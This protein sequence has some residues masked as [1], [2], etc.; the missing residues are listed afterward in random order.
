MIGPVFSLEL[1]LGSRRGRLD[2]LRRL[3]AGWLV[4]QWLVLFL[5]YLPGIR[6]GDPT[7]LAGVSRF[8]NTYLEIFVAQHF[9]LL[10]L[11]APVFVAGA[12]TDEKAKGT[13]THLLTADLTSWEI[14]AGKLLGRMAQVG[15]LALTGFPMLGFMGGY[16][17]LGWL[18][19]VSL[20]AVTVAPFFAL[21]AA[22]MLA[23]VRSVQTRDAVLRVYF[24][25]GLVLLGLWGTVEALDHFVIWKLTPNSPLHQRLLFGERMLHTLNPVHVL[26]PLW[27]VGDPRELGWRLLAGGLLWG[28]AGALCLGLAVWRLR[29]AYVRQLEA[30]AAPPRG[31][32]RRARAPVSE[33]PV[34]WKEQVVRGPGLIPWLRLV[35]RWLAVLAVAAATL[36]LS[37]SYLEKTEPEISFLIQGLVVLVLAS[38]ITGIRASGAVSG[39]R[40][41][42]TWEA[43]LLTPLE[44]WEIIEEKYQGILDSIYPYLLAF[45]VPAVGVALYAGVAAAVCTLATLLLTWAGMYYLGATGIWC[46][47]RSLS[48]WRSLLATLATGYG[49][50]LAVAFALVVIYVWLGCVAAFLKLFLALAGVADVDAA[51]HLIFGSAASLGL[52]WWLRRG[53]LIKIGKAEDQVDILE[54]SGRNFA[55]VL[56]RALRK[57]AEKLEARRLQ[58]AAVSGPQP[59]DEETI[60]P[61]PFAAQ[62]E[63]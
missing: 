60:P 38:L 59:E 28:L 35:P 18:T 25:V 2:V 27:T 20:P 43:L 11:A 21:A 6:A 52:A 9:L 55:G 50:S 32:G 42:Q 12:V 31:F 54:R 7:P 63:T 17:H 46:S 30:A 49:Y 61:S 34:R 8:V 1:L 44:T 5:I 40:E 39:E 48:S 33:D 29:P 13:F 36:L 41:R 4:L 57:H 58:E 56:A 16:G 47:S 14:V 24:W 10:F 53:A 62:P 15:L 3:Y 45:A 19:L 22:G 51:F 26:E 23:S 37:I